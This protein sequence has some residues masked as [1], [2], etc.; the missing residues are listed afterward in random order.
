MPYAIFLLIQ[1]TDDSTNVKQVKYSTRHANN[2]DSIQYKL[3][4]SNYP[5]QPITCCP[6]T[7]VSAT[8]GPTTASFSSEM[9]M[10]SIGVFKALS[11]GYYKQAGNSF[12]V[13]NA[14]QNTTTKDGDLRKITNTY[15]R[16]NSQMPTFTGD[17][18]SLAS[19]TANIER[20][21]W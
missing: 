20:G 11:T 8:D 9:F 7:N 3:K 12:Q 14:G 18:N 15:E 6:S 13:L 2:V 4:N 21:G 10:E 19:T 17:V 5:I 1:R 16:E